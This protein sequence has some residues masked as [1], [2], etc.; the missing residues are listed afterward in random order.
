MSKMYL[1]NS[2]V[3]WKIFEE[4]AL[5]TSI[6]TG[7]QKGLK[8]IERERHLRDITYTTEKW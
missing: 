6:F 7:N 1:L 8:G 4:I 3:K 5:I 2:P